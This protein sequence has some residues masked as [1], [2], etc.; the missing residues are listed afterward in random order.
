M[1]HMLLVSPSSTVAKYYCKYCIGIEAHFLKGIA[2]I[3]VVGYQNLAY[4]QHHAL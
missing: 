2:R 1:T 4:L 3:D